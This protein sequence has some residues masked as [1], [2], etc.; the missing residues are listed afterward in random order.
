MTYSSDVERAEQKEI[1]KAELAGWVVGDGYYGKY[2]RNKKTTLFGVITINDDEFAKVT[3]IFKNLFGS[4]TFPLRKYR[5]L[6]I[7]IFVVA[8]Q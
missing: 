7:L 5:G 6:L 1:E 3:E 2:G 8:H 4:Y